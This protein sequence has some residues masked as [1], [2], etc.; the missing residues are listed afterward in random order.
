MHACR[1][2]RHADDRLNVP[3]GDAHATARRLAAQLRV[4][5]LDLLLVD[6]LQRGADVLPRVHNV[7]AQQQLVDR[8]GGRALRGGAV[9]LVGI[10][11]G[12]V[13]VGAHVRLDDKLGEAHVAL[14]VDGV[15]HDADAVE[16]REDGVRQIDILRKRL[17]AIVAPAD[18]VGGGHDRATRLQRGDDTRLGDGD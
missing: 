2:L 12:E 6:R 3:H 7:L 15:A 16:A 11:L 13:W 14:W 18:W 10:L 9:G 8:A 17:R 4:H 5:A 1:C